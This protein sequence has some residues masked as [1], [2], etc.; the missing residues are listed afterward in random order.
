MYNSVWELRLTIYLCRKKEDAAEGRRDVRGRLWHGGGCQSPGGPWLGWGPR[1][2]K[3]GEE[4]GEEDAQGPKGGPASRNGVKLRGRGEDEKE[5]E[6]KEGNMS[7]TLYYSLHHITLWI[8]LRERDPSVDPAR[9]GV[10]LLVKG[11]YGSNS[12]SAGPTPVGSLGHGSGFN[13]V[14]IFFLFGLYFYTDPGS[15]NRD[16]D[17]F[18]VLVL[19]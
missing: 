9:R 16:R 12:G 8:Y 2:G 1:G 6:E 15:G 19:G 17:S 14:L 4:E 5:E 13:F 18:F 10:D 11:C 7:F 3:C